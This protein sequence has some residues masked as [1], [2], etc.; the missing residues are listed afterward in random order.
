[1]DERSEEHKSL[2][3]HF[4]LRTYGGKVSLLLGLTLDNLDKLSRVNS[5][6]NLRSFNEHVIYGTK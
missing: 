2:C 6:N 4:A 5:D 3:E 1:M